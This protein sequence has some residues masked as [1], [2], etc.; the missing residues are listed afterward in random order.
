MRER[1]R[2]LISVGRGSVNGVAPAMAGKKT[3]LEVN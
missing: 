1:E 3:L 2:S